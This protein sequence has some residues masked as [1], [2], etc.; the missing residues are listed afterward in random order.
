M[1]MFTAF[2]PPAFPR[3]AHD[4]A[5]AR[6]REL[7]N[8]PL[9]EVALLATVDVANATYYQTASDRVAPEDLT[10]L[11]AAIRELAAAHGYPNQQ[12]RGHS[13]VFDQQLSV[14]LVEQLNILPA[15][16][17]EEG[18]WSFL[19][20][21]VCPDVALWR[22]P[23]NLN[24]NGEVR[25]NY[26]RL[27]GKPRNVFRRAWWRGYVLGPQ[28]SSQLLEDESVGI[29]E[30]PSIGGSPRLARAV[31]TEHLN[32]VGRGGI[33]SRQDLL[34]DA[35]KRLRR[36]MGQISVHSLTDLQLNTLVRTA[37]DAAR[38]ATSPLAEA[39]GNASAS[40]I[41]LFRTLVG[42]LWARLEPNI[43]EVEWSTMTELLEDIHKHRDE[44]AGNR[45]LAVEIVDDL[46]RLIDGWDSY[47]SE[48][49]G[50]VHAAVRYFLDSDDDIPDDLPTGL[51]D[52]SEVVDAA[53]EAL[54]LVR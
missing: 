46:E 14:L 29:M 35:I 42:E 52:D 23:N 25:E 16:A 10:T 38:S 17:A 2:A 12:A 3:M 30:R 31:A 50:V 7:S 8:R 45:D 43:T 39:S 22:Y 40:E 26:E 36:R 11:R 33:R 21:N 54:G 51:D 6:V 1:V 9:S 19:T 41:Y 44:L 48:S 18:V 24:V 28:L 13:L 27:V 53:F 15:D 49:R 32:Q 5:E 20:L 34:R 37:F 4:D 47:T